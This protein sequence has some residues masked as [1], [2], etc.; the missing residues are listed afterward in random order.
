METGKATAAG[1]QK[2]KKK[3]GSKGKS[4]GLRERERQGPVLQLWPDGA[5]RCTVHQPTVERAR[6]RGRKRQRERVSKGKRQGKGR[7]VLEVRRVWA[8]DGG[9]WERKGERAKQ[10]EHQ[11]GVR[12]TSG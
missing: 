6:E 1:P 5:L 2:A 3:T 9:M 10:L 11:Y 12:T 4:T 8:Q 7:P